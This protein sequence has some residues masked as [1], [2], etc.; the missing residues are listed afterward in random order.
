M[1]GGGGGGTDTT[2]LTLLIIHTFDVVLFHFLAVSQLIQSVT[3]V[4]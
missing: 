3:V 1:G 4:V 2:H